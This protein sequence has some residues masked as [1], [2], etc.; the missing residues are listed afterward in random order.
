MR[1]RSGKAL[2]GLGSLWDQEA[3]SRQQKSPVPAALAAAVSASPSLQAEKKRKVEKI[4]PSPP[5][6]QSS[7]SESD[8]SS[9]S[10]TNRPPKKALRNGDHE[11]DDDDESVASNAIASAA[12]VAPAAVAAASSVK[13]TM[14]RG[15]G[16]PV[17]PNG[18]RVKDSSAAAAA[19]VAA[20][21][22]RE[23]RDGTAREA[24]EQFDLGTRRTIKQFT[25]LQAA[26]IAANVYQQDIYD[27]ICGG[28]ESTGDFGWR[29]PRSGGTTAAAA[30]SG[31]VTTS[32]TAA[33]AARNS[34][35][36]T[37]PRTTSGGAIPSRFQ[38]SDRYNVSLSK[39]TI[40][41][42]SL[43]LFLDTP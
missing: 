9:S 26:A 33:T 4:S 8:S 28:K 12:A 13:Q 36:I 2:R 27:C 25:S 16:A 22:Q 40:N 41:L 14:Q 29:R 42:I 38:R 35:T 15:T 32:V 37:R 3:G 17:T 39:G 23:S 34:T 20:P 7:E 30:A 6:E 1:T 21:S 19:A 5:R 18:T 10:S 31:K 43:I 24:V 11:D